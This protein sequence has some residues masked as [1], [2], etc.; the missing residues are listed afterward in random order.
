MLKINEIYNY[1]C[2]DGMKLLDDKSIDCILSSPPYWQ[3]RDYG[4]TEQWGL[5]STYQGYLK[6]L[7][8]FMDE[9]KRVLKNEGTCWINLG[10]TYGTKSGS[11]K[12]NKYC[13]KLKD[14]G[15]ITNYNKPKNMEKCLLLLPHRFAIGCIDRGWILRND[16]IWAKPNGMPES[17]NDR[18]SKKHEFIFFFVKQRK[19]YFDLDII[20]EEHKQ[21]S[22][23]RSKRKYTQTENK[24]VAVCNLKAENMCNGKGKNPGDV[25]DF[26]SISTKGT[27][28]KHYAAYNKNLIIKPILVG[29]P[30]GGIILDPF[31][32]TGQTLKVAYNNNRN[33]IGFDGN[34]EYCDIANKYIKDIKNNL[35]EEI[36]NE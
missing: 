15:G 6:H 21:I 28:D 32:G 9:V 26:W 14:I 17:V 36:N 23:E 33:F 16:I 29:C 24:M 12:E 3:C 19:Y 13:N 8:E 25:S 35:F 34:K 7:W 30:E 31:A 11:F 20:R 10:D 2:L 27:K 22:I 1:L 18:F 5:E 4:F